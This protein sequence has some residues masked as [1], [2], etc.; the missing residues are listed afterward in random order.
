[1]L[2]LWNST[3]TISKRTCETRAPKLCRKILHFCGLN[4]NFGSR[5]IP[6]GDPGDESDIVE[7]LVPDLKTCFWLYITVNSVWFALVWYS[8][9]ST[10]IVSLLWNSSLIQN[11][12][13]INSIPKISIECQRFDFFA[14]LFSL[15]FGPS[16]GFSVSAYLRSEDNPC[17]LSNR[18]LLD[19]SNYRYLLE[20]I[21]LVD[22]SQ[23]NPEKI[24]W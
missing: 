14:I 3:D 8:G 21:T 10:N 18:L 13:F 19:S 23:F 4:E 5:E 11:L 7:T 2:T 17:Y 15:N 9:M 1:M 6:S 12:G 22:P 20:R 24:K 16:T